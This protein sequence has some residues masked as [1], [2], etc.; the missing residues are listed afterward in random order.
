VRTTP[1][2]A[3]TTAPAPIPQSSPAKKTYSNGDGL[4]EGD[5]FQFRLSGG[6]IYNLPTPTM[7]GARWN[8]PSGG[9]DSLCI[10]VRRTGERCC[11]GGGVGACKLKVQARDFLASGDGIAIE[12]RSSSIITGRGGCTMDPVKPN[13]NNLSY[14]SRGYV[15]PVQAQAQQAGCAFGAHAIFDRIAFFLDVPDE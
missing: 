6:E 11:M 5:E 4:E 10:R 1:T 13:W 3:P 12:V 14:S 9:S 8:F 7:K 15:L 2:V